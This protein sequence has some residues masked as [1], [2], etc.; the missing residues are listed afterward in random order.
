MICNIIHVCAF[1]GMQIL[2]IGVIFKKGTPIQLRNY[3]S[4]FPSRL[5]LQS[6]LIADVAISKRPLLFTVW[7][8]LRLRSHQNFWKR[9][10][11]A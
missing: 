4:P 2:R 8:Q 11:G 7:T 5:I 1:L 10:R 6:N 9:L 3:F